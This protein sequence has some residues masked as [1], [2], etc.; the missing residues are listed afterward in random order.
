MMNQGTANMPLLIRKYVLL[1]FP[2]IIF[3]WLANKLGEAYR[4]SPGDDFGTKVLNL[5]IGFI[6]AFQSMMP[7]LH[8][9][10]FLVGIV[11]AAGMWLMVLNKKKNAK[12]FRKDTEHGSARWGGKADIDPFLSKNPDDNII[13]TQTEGLT[14]NP[15]PSNPAY[16]RNK[17]MLVIG[18]SGS[19]KTR[20]VL[21]PNLMQCRSK[22]YPVSFVVTDPKGSILIE[23]GKMLRHFGYRIKVLN[24]INFGKSMHYNPFAYIK[25]EKDI[26]K[27]VTTLIANTKGEKKGGDEFWEKSEILLYTAL[28]AYLHYESPKSEQN[29]ATL[30]EMISA[31]EVKEEDE[32]FKNV[33]DL[34]FDRLE[35]KDPDHFAVRQ[36]RKFRLAAGKT[37]KSILVSCGARL[38][39]FDIAEIRE[40]TRYDELELDTI[41][42]E[43]TALFI[44]ISDTDASFNFLVSMAYTQLFNLLC[45]KADD[46]YGGRLP[47]HV[48]CLIESNYRLGHVFKPHQQTYT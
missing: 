20:F 21:K 18:G 22:T 24:T 37:L 28:I 48:R 26:L 33:V 31:M 15:R 5:Q 38:A 1:N 41:G 19:G 16:A 44:I 2:Y 13:L 6:D 7:S 36:Y 47:V 40:I 3:F 45:E 23:C 30:A 34:M 32:D 27:L 39:P 12:K 8:L 46:V 43:K 4:I 14:M 25:S 35:E 9:Q 11:G 17:N 29:F 10:D 42:D